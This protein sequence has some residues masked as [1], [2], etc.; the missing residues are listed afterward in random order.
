MCL[1]FHKHDK[2]KKEIPLLTFVKPKFGSRSHNGYSCRSPDDLKD[3]PLLDNPFGE[4]R[5]HQGR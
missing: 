2:T 5:G 3:R 4:E 1:D